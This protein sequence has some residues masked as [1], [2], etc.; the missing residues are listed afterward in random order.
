[1]A[2]LKQDPEADTEHQSTALENIRKLRMS[3]LKD[4]QSLEDQ[5]D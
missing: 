5:Q 3:L 1:M 4:Q 2:S